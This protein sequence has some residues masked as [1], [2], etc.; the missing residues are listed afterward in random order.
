MKIPGISNSSV[1]SF[2]K[3]IEP[4]KSS[5]TERQNKL[6][7][8]V[9]DIVNLTY[10]EDKQGRSY[11]DYFE[12][13]HNLDFYLKPIRE[14]NSLELYA[15]NDTEAPDLVKRYKKGFK[16]KESD[17]LDYIDFLH[18][19]NLD[20]YDK[21]ITFATCIFLFFGACFLGYKTPEPTKLGKT[22]GK[23]LVQKTT[24]KT[25]TIGSSY[26]FKRLAK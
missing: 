9:K 12:N 7:N 11:V 20:F 10:T 23:E 17:L 1:T 13:K 19:K 25:D 22:I 2:G 16:P 15:Y 14:N 24:E 5:Y 4:H 8:Y 6:A 21:A 18:E 3:I 26:L